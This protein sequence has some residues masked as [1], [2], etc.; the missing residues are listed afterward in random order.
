MVF[1]HLL[2]ASHSDWT[3]L[4]IDK[5]TLGEV[6][7]KLTGERGGG[8]ERDIFVCSK[9]RRENQWTNVHAAWPTT[10]TTGRCADCQL[11]TIAQDVCVGESRSR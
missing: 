6:S 5:T 11:S 2:L 1:H 10:I 3:E 9:V 7:R 8:G 4:A